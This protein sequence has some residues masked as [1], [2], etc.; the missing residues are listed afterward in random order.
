MQLSF[1]V[2]NLGLPKQYEGYKDTPGGSKGDLLRRKG[3]LP[4]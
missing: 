2:V 3:G 1:K 4:S